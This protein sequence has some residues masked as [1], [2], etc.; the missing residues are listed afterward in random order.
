M[1]TIKTIIFLAIVSLNTSLA[2]SY[3]PF[4]LSN[5]SWCEGIY[6]GGGGWPPSDTS[7]TFYKTNGT[8]LINDTN[9]TVIDKFDEGTYCY[10]REENKKVFC[11]YDAL[12]PEFVLYDFNIQ[13]GDTVYLPFDYGQ[14][15]YEGIVDYQDSLLIGSIY[16]KRFFISSWVGITL[17]EGVGSGEGL[18][19]CEIPWV[20]WYG[21]LKCFSLNDTIFDLTGN[22]NKSSGNCWLFINI[23]EYD[24]EVI[25]IHPNPA[26]NIVF[27]SGNGKYNLQLFNTLGELKIQTY[28]SSINLAVLSEGLYIL[29]IYSSKNTLIKQAKVLRLNAR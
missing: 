29:N 15:T 18:M 9:Y 14:S 2:Q 7:S 26:Q 5:A 13:L 27:I 10:L 25:F 20:D 23:Q 19:Y 28:A 6:F 1:K 16:H 17:I 12:S 3:I 11:R 8:I 22:G 24:P 21:V 4:P